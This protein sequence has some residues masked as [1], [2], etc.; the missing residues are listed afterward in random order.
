MPKYRVHGAVVGS[1]YLGEFEAKNADEAIKKA[2]ESRAG[3]VSLCHQCAD[4]CEDA[5]IDID[6]T[7]AELVEEPKPKTKA[8]RRREEFDA[9][10]LG[11]VKPGYGWVAGGMASH[12]GW[13]ESDVAK[14]FARL[15][16]SGDLRRDVGGIHYLVLARLATRAAMA[17]DEPKTKRAGKAGGT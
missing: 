17:T 10:V 12:L 15:V 9:M 3:S 5:S 2:V 11:A 7:S 1:K 13:P 4:E 6:N 8:S 16:K 14:S